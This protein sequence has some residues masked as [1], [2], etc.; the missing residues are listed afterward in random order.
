MLIESNVE[1]G[2]FHVVLLLEMAFC[3]VL[4]RLGSDLSSD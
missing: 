2:L 1:L 4:V 3:R